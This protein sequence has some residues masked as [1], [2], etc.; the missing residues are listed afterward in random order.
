METLTPLL[1]LLHIPFKNINV[2][3]FD[4]NEYR[5]NIE[6]DEA[7]LLIGYHG[8]NLLS[9][10]H[11]LKVLLH[12]K[13]EQTFSVTL[14][15][16][17]YRKRQEE[18]VLVMAEERVD[19]ARQSTAPQKLP[20]MSPYFRRLVHLHL[21]KPEFSDIITAS[22]GQGNFRAVVISKVAQ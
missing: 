5:V 15:V 3:S 16:D 9:L 19:R 7:Q 6:T 22:E 21:A 13:A 12:K 2:E 17:N 14:D 4:D 11:L 10:Q 20:P 8:G 1:E 18:S